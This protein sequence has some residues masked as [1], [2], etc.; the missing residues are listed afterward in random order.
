[1]RAVPRH[2]VSHP[3]ATARRH[4]TREMAADD[5]PQK[6]A[7]KRAMKTRIIAEYL[8][9]R[10]LDRFQQPA[11]LDRFDDEIPRAEPD[12]LEDLRLLMQRGAHH[13]PSARVDRED[14][15]QR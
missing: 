10:L 3:N 15:G 13:H 12:R 5:V 14:L 9:E 1:M 11:R 4:G 7:A 8:S 2:G 6:P